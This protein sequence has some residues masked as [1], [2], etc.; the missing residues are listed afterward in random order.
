MKENDDSYQNIK[1]MAIIIDGID[2]KE[3]NTRYKK[4]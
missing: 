3:L 1:I 4:A 2:S